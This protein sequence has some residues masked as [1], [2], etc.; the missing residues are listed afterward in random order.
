M[1]TF[2]LFSIE[3]N[4]FLYFN[5]KICFVSFRFRYFLDIFE[6]NTFYFPF[7]NSELSIKRFVSFRYRNELKIRPKKRIGFMHVDITSQ[8]TGYS[9]KN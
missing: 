6:R 2:R 1:S 7:D 8:D 5:A 9:F 3:N 4:L